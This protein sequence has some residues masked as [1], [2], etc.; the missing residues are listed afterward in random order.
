MLGFSWTPAAKGQL[1]VYGPP[2][3]GAFVK[4]A[5][6]YLS[7]PIAIYAAQS[8]PIPPLSETV[9]AH[10]IDVTRPTEVYRDD[11]VRVSAVENSHYVTIPEN[12]R[13]TGAARSYSY[14][15]DTPDRSVVFSGDTGPSRD[16]EELAMGADVLVIEVMDMDAIITWI[17]KGYSGNEQDLKSTIDHMLQEHISPQE[18]G[19]LA[20]RAGVKFV[21][22]THIAPGDDDE[23]D[24][25][26]YTQGVREVFLG[27]VVVAQDGAEY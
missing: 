20:T 14:R 18:V 26:R 8:P 17:K 23:T 2:G 22:L 7:L 10:D 6:D 13:P 9:K 27:P 5:L 15:F 3:T 11:K 25:R 24:L 19:R 21:I 4:S 16:L 12:K 1:D